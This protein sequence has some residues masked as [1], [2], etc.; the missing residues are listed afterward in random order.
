MEVMKVFF[1]VVYAK[2]PIF[3]NSKIKNSLDE[4]LFF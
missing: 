4:L 2:T 3:E 1:N